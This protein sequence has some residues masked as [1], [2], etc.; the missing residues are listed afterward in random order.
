[1]FTALCVLPHNL[2]PHTN[3]NTYKGFSFLIG[4]DPTKGV[5][6]Q[7]PFSSNYKSWAFI[8]TYGSNSFILTAA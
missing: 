2:H 1:M 6:L 3:T 7:L 4:L 8:Y 5:S